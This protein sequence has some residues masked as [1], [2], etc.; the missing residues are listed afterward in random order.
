MKTA[1]AALSFTLLLA[2][3]LSHAGVEPP[4]PREEVPLAGRLGVSAD[5][6]DHLQEIPIEI[7]GRGPTAPRPERVFAGHAGGDRFVFRITFAEPFCREDWVFHLYADLDD[8]PETGRQDSPSFL[9]TDMMYSFVAGRNDPRFM[10]PAVRVSEVVPVRGVVLGNAVYVSDDIRVPLQDGRTQFRIRLLSHLRSENRDSYSSGWNEVRIPVDPERSAPRLPIPEPFG[11]ASL[12]MP[13]FAELAYRVW[14]DPGTVR[15]RPA[16]ARVQGYQVLMND[17]FDGTGLAEER[18]VWPSPV[19]GAYHVGLVLSAQPERLQSQRRMDELRAAD[20][21]GSE[22][23]GGPAGLDLLV[24]GK[25]VGTVVGH[26]RA[27]GDTF[28]FTTEPVGLQKGQPIEVRSAEYSGPTVFHSVHLAPQPPQVPPLRIENLTA[29]HMP[30]EPGELPNR[31]MV[32]WTSNRPT[33]AVVRAT[34]LD[35]AEEAIELP[36]RG[37]VNNHFIVLTPELPGEAWELEIVCREAE[38]EAFAAQQVRTRFLVHRD[39]AAHQQAHGLAPVREPQVVRIPL[40]VQESADQGRTAWPL[41]SGVPLPQGLLPDPSTV[42]LRDAAG[43]EVAVQTQ[44]LAWWPDGGSVQWLLLDFFADTTAGE[45]SRY[46]LEVNVPSAVPATSGIRIEAATSAQAG[47]VAPRGRV[48]APVTVDTGPLTLR[49]G[50]GGFDPFADVTVA[51][52][53]MPREGGGFQLTDGDGNT[54]SSTNE[55]PEEI[56]I[57]QQGPLRA[58]LAIRGRLVDGRGNAYMRY[59]CRLHFHAGRPSVRA[60]FT[61]END[62]LRPDMNHLSRLWVTVPADLS[63]AAVTVGGDGQPLE[64]EPGG[65]LL[66]DED[67]RF[68]GSVEGRHADG[69]LLARSSAQ[70]LGVAVRDFWQLYPKAF[71]R[72]PQGVSLELLPELPPD[73]YA[74]VDDAAR[75]Q[76][77]FWNDGGRYRLRTGVRLTTEFAVDWQPEL[78]PETPAEYRAGRWWSQPLFAA[79]TPDWYCGTGVLDTLVPRRAGHFDRYEQQLDTAFARFR[80]R[81]ERE[82]EYGFMNYGDWFGERTWNWGNIEYDTPWA[83][84]AN[85]LRTGNLEMLQHAAAAAAHAADIDTIHHHADPNRV[86]FVYT[87]CTGHTAGYFPREWKDMGG[88]NVHGGNRGGHIWSQ[89]KYALW[90]LTGE[91]RLRET[92][93]KI[94]HMLA[95]YTT[96]FRIGAERSVGW[97]MIATMAGYEST[98]NP[99]YRNAAQLMADIVIWSQHPERGLWGHWIDPNECDH[100]PRCWGAKPFM[101]GV[102]LRGM[103]MVHR[104]ETRQD[105]W[106]SMLRNVD[107]LFG[108]AYVAEGER[109]GFVYSGCRHERFSA[110]GAVSRLS[111]IGPGIAY[112][113][114]HDPEQRHLPM[115][116][117]AARLYFQQ[118]GISDFGKS[119]TQATC[120]LPTVMHDLTKLGLTD[121]ADPPGRPDMETP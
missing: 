5:F 70:S 49:L 48:A 71:R 25:R 108:E 120:F 92:A 15:L 118:A 43:D 79:C 13:N 105:V 89:G 42:R 116:E 3:P 112:V 88:F 68:V 117:Q 59:L 54:Y 28:F 16:D 2:V 119:F 93:D 103:K 4:G 22:R 100:A 65:Y 61:L 85:F 36:G 37:R 84:A 97:P 27:S 55:P 26:P 39:P 30:D 44:A 47:P 1:I 17:D 111:L 33:E 21:A 96:D 23:R 40:A 82:R 9:G 75:T 63:E 69:W 62:V 60:V 106:D 50:S 101:T 102:L 90:A 81:Q 86:G 52:R 95:H 8:D 6:A 58:T 20:S 72:K 76:W 98:G 67:F 56:L 110:R 121:F 107:F 34:R 64:L 73:Q 87:H 31:V 35:V 57:E 46:T 45:T 78:C 12:T 18:A 14:Q 91:E 38:Q 83:L 115:L 104:S 109:P 114:L 24:D 53:K 77:Y 113:V 29:W 11:V 7:S 80:Q 51:G 41:R 94:T 32:A 74:D 99:F 19:A 66:Q 10:N